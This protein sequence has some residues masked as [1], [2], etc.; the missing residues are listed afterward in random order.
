MKNRNDRAYAGNSSID[1]KGIDAA[2]LELF[3]LPD[4]SDRPRPKHQRL[5]QYDQFGLVWLLRVRR[6]VALTNDSASIATANGGR[7]SYFRPK[8][9]EGEQR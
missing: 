9:T 4:V 2:A 3:G 8:S 6:P 5:S 7:L 1:F